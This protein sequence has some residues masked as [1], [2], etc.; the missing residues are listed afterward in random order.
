VRYFL[1][2]LGNVVAMIVISGSLVA[3]AAAV[4]SSQRV[5]SWVRTTPANMDGLEFGKDGKVFV[6]VGNGNDATTA[7]YSVLDDGRL[8]ISMGRRR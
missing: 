6:Y 7:D 4:Q 3:G 5:G 8:N 2:L 1:G